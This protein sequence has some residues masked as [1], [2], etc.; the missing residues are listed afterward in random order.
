[1]GPGAIRIKRPRGRQIRGQPAEG[2]RRLELPKEGLGT[3]F[4]RHRGHAQQGHRRQVQGLGPGCRLQGPG[5][6]R[7][8]I[9]GIG[10]KT[11][12]IGRIRCG[13]MRSSTA[14]PAR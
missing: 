12:R 13:A 9:P 1:M 11:K 8:G 10:G 3:G 4:G 6:Q 7:H 2:W 14:P 5:L